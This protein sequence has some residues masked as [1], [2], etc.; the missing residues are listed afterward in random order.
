M[1]RTQ[2]RMGNRIEV[3]G[4]SLIPIEQIRLQGDYNDRALWLHAQADPVALVICGAG[5]PYALSLGARALSLSEL[6][7]QLPELAS[8][9]SLAIGL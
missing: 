5:Q 7:R 1:K 6:R 9:I 3:A 8:A 2:L 4:L